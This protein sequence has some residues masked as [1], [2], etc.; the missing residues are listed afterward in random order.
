[1]DRSHVDLPIDRL[2]IPPKHLSVA[3]AMKCAG[4]QLSALFSKK[5]RA[6]PSA[7]TKCRTYATQAGVRSVLCDVS[8]ELT[9]ITL[10]YAI[11]LK[12]TPPLRD[13]LVHVDIGIRVWSKATPLRST[14]VPRE[15]EVRKDQAHHIGTAA[16]RHDDAETA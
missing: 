14:P 1:M 6:R 7:V 16:A 5:R 8:R 3:F 4:R 13:S 9:M 2:V 15:G 11:A 10:R 12:V